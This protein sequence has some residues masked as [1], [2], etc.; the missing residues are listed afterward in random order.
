MQH[1]G[2]RKANE[3]AVLSIVAFNPGVSNAEISRLSGL[4]PQTVSAILADVEKAGLISRG[5]VLRGR[6][7][8]PAT[9]IF[10]RPDGRYC[11]GCEIGWR[12]L[13][14]VLINLHGE[15][16]VERQDVHDF[17]DARTI[18]GRVGEHARALAETL[19]PEARGRLAGLG[20]AMPTY[21]WRTIEEVGADAEQVRLWQELDLTRALSAET[22]LEVTIYNDGNAACWSELIATPRPRPSDVIYFLVSHFIA[23]GVIGQG[24]LWEGPSGNSANLGS[25]L[26]DAR[27]DGP[28][29]AHHVASLGALAD[30]L[31]AAGRPRPVGPYGA[32][33]WDG[34]EP[35]LGEWL[36]AGAVALARVIFNTAVVIEAKVAVIDGAM[37][38]PVVE[39]LVER[40]VHHL[41][42]LPSTSLGPP[43]VMGG[44]LGPLA[45][46]IGAA[47]LPLYRR[48]LSRSLADITG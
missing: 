46:A 4:A 45:P 2:L 21:I 17:P 9:P 14:S 13:Q 44:R 38:R 20:I 47:E 28:R 5:Q 48:Y 10:L 34:F 27:D 6:R 40:V 8:Q 35:V 41:G 42:T 1:N 18:V 25:M 26:I 24:T 30:R 11:L 37:P 33:D 43:Q 19:A 3:R 15:V 23:A 32:W 29:V 36:E 39:R 16:Q 7:G 22:G 31:E 12:H